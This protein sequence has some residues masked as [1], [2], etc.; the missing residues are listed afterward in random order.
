[1][2]LIFTAL[3]FLL[4]PIAV[5]AQ[6]DVT[7]QFER[8][9]NE[10]LECYDLEAMLETCLEAIQFNPFIFREVRG[11]FPIKQNNEYHVIFW[12][13]TFQPTVFAT[14]IYDKASQTGK[15]DTTKRELNPF[16]AG[17]LQM[18]DQAAADHKKDTQYRHLPNA[19]EVLIPISTPYGN[20]VFCMPRPREPYMF[21]L[22]NDVE[23]EFD[24]QFR[25]NSKK[26]IHS[27]TTFICIDPAEENEDPKNMM[28]THHHLGEKLQGISATDIASLCQYGNQFEWGA[29]AI[30][31]EKVSYSLEFATMHLF[32]WPSEHAAD[33]RKKLINTPEIQTILE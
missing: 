11:W 8:E 4:H 19:R 28:A 30:V 3:A 33:L 26:V 15:L 7:M 14:Y 1:M 10:G 27:K 22:G 2:K 12:E 29:Y 18:L 6:Q 25:L 16:E 20:K 32:K 13:N 23:Y 24:S 5:Q 17:I 31:E 9:L 21:I